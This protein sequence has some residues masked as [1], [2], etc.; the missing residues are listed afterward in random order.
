MD[1]GTVEFM[2]KLC[3]ALTAEKG[4]SLDYST[5]LAAHL[6]QAKTAPPSP[7][8]ARDLA[9]K[10]ANLIFTPGAGWNKAGHVRL[11][12]TAKSDGVMMAGWM[13]QNMVDAVEKLLKE[14]GL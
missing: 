12:T 8:R 11:F 5:I 1:D 3:G 14:N 2:K 7:G 4:L 9:V 13:E 10:I 6:D